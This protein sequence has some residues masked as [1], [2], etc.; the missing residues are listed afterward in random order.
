MPRVHWPAQPTVESG[1]VFSAA[2]IRYAHGAAISWLHGESLASF[3]LPHVRL[4][5]TDVYQTD[6]QTIWELWAIHAAQLAYYRLLVKINYGDAI[7]RTWAY[8]MQVS[9][10]NGATWYTAREASGTQ[11]TYQTHDGTIDL[12]AVADGSGG[13]IADHLTVGRVYKWRLQVRVAV[14]GEPADC[15]VHLVPWS[16]GTRKSVAAGDGWQTPPTFTAATSNPAHLNTLAHDAR[17]LQHALPPGEAS[18]SLPALHTVTFSE[19]W[20]ELTRLVYRYRPNMLY[21]VALGSAWSNET[22]QWRVKVETDT[23]S[24]VVYT[25]GAITGD[26]AQEL[27]DYSWANAQMIDL[28]DGAAAAALAAAGITLTLGDWYRVV[29]EIYTTASPGRAWAIGAAV[30]RTS[31]NTPGA[32][33]TVPHLWAHG[34]TNIG[35]TYLNQL[36]ASLTALYSGSEALHFDAQGVDV[37]AQGSGH[38]LAHRRR[39]LRYV[40]PDQPRIYYGPDLDRTYDPPAA[41]TPEPVDLDA[42]G[43]P[44]GS[45]YYVTG[46]ETCMEADSE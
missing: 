35:P 28:T 23:L 46:A 40:A 29:V 13:F 12:T 19:T 44:Y 1:S 4:P 30:Y 14:Q 15:T 45:I 34:D 25:S 39:Y 32:G 26:E 22:W 41:A 17:A 36:S 11:N 5:S 6:Y 7:N 38:A 42:V 37:V 16:I 18:T 27:E 21:V 31:D 2:M 10:D 33:Y 9:P 24:A 20:E 43:V 3:A 8:R